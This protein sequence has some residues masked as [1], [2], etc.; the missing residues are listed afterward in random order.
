MNDF[1]EPLMNV[2][3]RVKKGKFLAK[4]FAGAL[5][6]INDLAWKNGIGKK[7]WDEFHKY[8]E[9]GQ[10]KPLVE[11]KEL[12]NKIAKVY[13]TEEV[14][15]YLMKVESKEIEDFLPQEGKVLDAGCGTGR[16]SIK[17]ARSGCEVVGVDFSREML[18]EAKKKSKGLKIKYKFGDIRKL[19]LKKNTFDHV[20][21]TLVLN[22]LKDWKKA[23]RQLVKVT[24]P[25]GSIVISNIHPER[26]E[27]KIRG[28]FP[29][30]KT[31]RKELWVEEWRIPISDLIRTTK[32]KLMGL[33]EIANSYLAGKA[34]L[35]TS[36]S[37]FLMI[38]KFRK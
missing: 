13:E 4:D 3:R 9:S 19:N 25:G 34:G 18:K 28:V 11:T 30:S 21:C 14:R 31:G 23:V 27:G 22:H 6:S 16:Y 2:I 15:R 5:I 36:K 33:T 37:P 24:K 12:Y 10:E 35:R 20:I 32:C 17:M 26:F 1:R 7:M 38:A 29:F 8:Y